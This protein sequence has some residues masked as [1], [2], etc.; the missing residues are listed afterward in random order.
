M[1]ALFAA[2]CAWAMWA[3]P[4]AAQVLYF[5]AENYGR[6]NKV[7]T[8]SANNQQVLEVLMGRTDVF[9][10]I[11]DF[12]TA[13]PFRRIGRAVGM[14]DLLVRLPDGRQVNTTCTATLITPNRAITNNHCIPGADFTAIRAQLRLGFLDRVREPGETFDVRLPAIETNRALDYAIV[15]VVGVPTDRYPPLQFSTAPPRARQS[16]YM[17]HHPAGYPQRLTRVRCQSAEPAVQES[18]LVHHCDTLGGSSGAL[19]LAMENNRIIGLHFAG[20]PDAVRPMNYAVPAT[21]LVNSSSELARIIRLTSTTAP[22][23]TPPTTAQSTSANVAVL[24][25]QGMDRY[26]GTGGVA[27][28]YTEA[29]RLLRQAADQGHAG[30]QNQLGFMYRTGQGVTRND[31]EAVRYFRL[32]ADQGYAFG[33]Y[34]LG[35]LYGDGIGVTRSDTEAVRLYRLAAGRGHAGAQAALGY[36][37]QNGRGVAQDDAEA[38]R[39]YRLAADQN[40]ASAH[41]NLAY[42]YEFG[43]GTERNYAESIRYYRLAIGANNTAA[44]VNLALMYTDGRGVTRD[45]AEAVR[46]LQPA[47]QQGFAPAQTQLG[48]L[49]SNGRGVARDD[50]EAVR[51]FTLAANQGHAGGQVSLGT[52]YETGRGVTA[53]RAEAVRLYRLA[54]RQGNTSAQGHLTRLGETW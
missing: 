19:V 13:D 16:L 43:R 10:T 48:Y 53:N 14:L 44:M 22:P 31:S 35:V 24:F 2:M 50:V 54:A 32:S 4:A 25:S 41:F 42:M 12:E 49:Y 8:E 1:R 6:P 3:A 40:N 30:A 9:E 17:I 36:M 51:L 11:Y 20:V 18:R 38:V 46:I 33:Q 34:N 23:V 29:A 26:Y 45:D 52:M 7:F 39:L 28:D 37:Y 15:E 27:R 47:V 21:Q 5:P